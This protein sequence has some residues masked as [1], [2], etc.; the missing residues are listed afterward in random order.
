MYLAISRHK[1]KL[2]LLAGAAAAVAFAAGDV[3][4]QEQP[5]KGGKLT[6]HI[7][8]DIGGFDHIKVPQGGMGRYQVLWAVHE[9]LF[10]L[11][12]GGNPVPR[13]AVK[14]SPSDNFKTWRV[15]LRKGVKFSNG[16]ELTSEAYT[17]HFARL[18]GSGLAG[19]FKAQLG[20][21]L[22]KVTGPDKHTVEFQFAEPNLAFI[23]AMATG[24]NYIWYLNAP[25][26]AKKNENDPNYNRMSAGAGAYMVKEWVPGKG[27]TLVKNPN[28]WNPKEQHLDELFYRITT[29]PE[30]A[31]AWNAFAAG[32]LDVMWS[33]NG[34]GLARARKEGDKYNIA[35]GHRG[36]LHMSINFQAI[37]K[38]LE[39]N[40]VRLALAH[41]IDRK[42]IIKI[43]G[44]NAPT[45]ADQSFPP[46]SKWF[47]DNIAYPE[48]NP[49][50]AKKLLAEFG[51]PIPVLP[52]WT[53]N[54]PAMRK[55]AEIIQAMWK[56]VGVESELKV[57]GRGPT[58]VVFKIVKGETPTWANPRGSL[59]HP[60]VF[61]MDLHSQSK[62]NIWR[63][64]SPKLDAAIAKVRAARTDA[65]IKAAHCAFEQAKTEV[66]PYMPIQYAPNAIMAQKHVGGVVP[67]HDP[68]LGYHRFWRKK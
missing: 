54:I 19:R 15:E 28:Y 5:V 61:N 38:P 30:T 41:A 27:V 10:E 34:S 46:G 21:N 62:N 66:V 58:G 2:S 68:L 18:L 48:F 43:V 29:G 9:R 24:G 45:F 11:D 7:N 49:E 4:A 55:T 37:H 14:A 6:V 60:T 40:R 20:S 16:E 17:H 3:A 52:I 36:Q 8:R 63:I 35:N 50:K 44:R 65:E 67:P 13:L 57:G 31:A 39:D 23:E 26:F 59:V 47:C 1:F 64:K 32:D 33:L 56:K 42:A 12:S 22:Q 53:L 51:Q 25:G